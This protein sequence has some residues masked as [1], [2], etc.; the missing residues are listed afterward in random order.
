MS[1]K[2]FFITA[3]I[4]F[5]SLLQPALASDT[6]PSIPSPAELDDPVLPAASEIAAADRTT[7][8][9][10][11][12]QIFETQQIERTDGSPDSF[13]GTVRINPAF[14]T[15]PA[16]PIVGADGSIL[17]VGLPPDMARLQLN[18]AGEQ[19][20]LF[21]FDEQKDAR[22][23]LRHV[24]MNVL[25]YQGAYARFSIDDRKGLIYGAIY[26]PNRTLRIVPGVTAGQQQVHMSDSHRR[27]T[28]PSAL[29]EQSHPSVR[30]LA[31]RHQEL[32]S[33]AMIRAE[34]AE[35]RHESRSSYL[36]GGDL[37]RLQ[38]IDAKEFVRAA[39]NL[40]S[41]TQ[42]NGDETFQI[43]E[44]QPTSGGVQ[45]IRLQQLI[46]GVP[47][48]ALNE[49]VVDASGKIL[50]LSTL[51]APR[52]FA[53]I[54]PFLSQADAW[55]R[56]ITAWEALESSK[57]T[58][59]G[60]APRARLLYRPTTSINDLELIY[61]FRF[62]S[63]SPQLEYLARVNA[64]SGSTAVVRLISY[65]YAYLTCNDIY[66][67][68]IPTAP[69]SQCPATLM[70]PLPLYAAPAAANYN[71]PQPPPA[72]SGNAGCA[73]VDSV[74]AATVL[75]GMR[76][77]LPAAAATNPS[78]V[79]G[80]CSQM[81]TIHV[82]QDMRFATEASS[83]ILGVIFLPAN[84]ASAE[85][86]AHEIA[87][88]YHYKYNESL[89]VAT[90]LFAS[91][92]ME[93]MGY[94]IPGLYGA[95]SSDPSRYG[96]LWTFGDGPG[97]TGGVMSANNPDFRYWQDIDNRNDPTVTGHKAGQVI[98]R[99]FRRLKEISGVGNQRLLGIAL[100]TIDGIADADGNG[101]DAGDFR[102]AVLAALHPNETALKNAVN[103]VYAELYNAT[104]SGPVGPP[105]PPGEPG[106]IGSPSAPAPYWGSFSFC[107]TY[108]GTPV[109]IYQTFW[110]ASPGATLYG[111]YAK[112]FQEPAYRYT[113][114]TAATTSYIY[115]N[116]TGDGRVS[117]CNANG[118]SGLSVDAVGVSHQPQ[119]GG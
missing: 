36:R 96:D 117:A 115:T 14:L 28:P 76:T 95:L 85:T 48:D 87:H 54:K 72:A 104:A 65:N 67:P 107:G 60:S 30:L 74:N 44:T 52:D 64:V 69:P 106:P 21:F 112:T 23:G 78:G 111:L 16:A 22:Y 55:S 90:Q 70:A 53:R 77:A 56:V 75:N 7:L 88:V 89:S 57:F 49:V 103:T 51:L 114:S 98:F 119:C 43:T 113:D 29:V 79:G 86:V 5:F 73:G 9:R 19:Y 17:G 38:K 97:Y 83:T 41:I 92:V 4:L 46:G 1:T 45:R 81:G 94:V 37:G 110:A 27:S 105:L 62:I 2:K 102:R 40:A 101:W 63:G 59:D 58:T 3:L 12:P 91:A 26:T 99:F 20:E 11:I 33:V 24:T 100:A 108:Q 82:I 10:L 71:C 31:W 39:T 15:K 47:V 116:T 109:S 25:N 6:A 18:I 32:E 84:E 35:A 68:S 34:Y 61:E 93:G 42:F 118:C 80:C 8:S 13:L 66:I 50:S